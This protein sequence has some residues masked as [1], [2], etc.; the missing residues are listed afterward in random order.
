MRDET[1]QEEQK[2]TMLGK[3]T[4][5]SDQVESGCIGYV[6]VKWRPLPTSLANNRQ[7]SKACILGLVKKSASKMRPVHSERL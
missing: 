7:F 4:L 2:K 6:L 1:Q 5:E 3:N